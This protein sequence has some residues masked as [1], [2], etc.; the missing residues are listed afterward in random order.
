[1]SAIDLFGTLL[2]GW[3]Y[4][5]IEEEGVLSTGNYA[6]IVQ[7]PFQGWLRGVFFETNNPAVKFII[8]V[9]NF[10]KSSWVWALY[11][12]GLTYQNPS[13]PYLARYDTTKN[14]YSIFWIPNPPLPVNQSVQAYAYVDNSAN[15]GMPSAPSTAEYHIELVFEQILDKEAFAESLRDLIRPVVKELFETIV[16]GGVRA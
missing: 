16:I 14:L 3:N 2:K 6:P 8:Q 9:D 13:L 12:A 15:G 7:I 4:G 10:I 5:M 11:S 1:M